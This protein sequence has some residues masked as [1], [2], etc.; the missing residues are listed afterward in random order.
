VLSAKAD[1]LVGYTGFA[2][3]LFSGVAG[4]A[5][6]VLRRRNPDEPRPFRA[7]GYPLAPGIFV[8]V[9]ALILLNAIWRSPGPTGAGVLV[10][11]AGL[12][13]YYWLR[14]AALRATRN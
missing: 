6:F 4:A 12:P 7:W 9:S 11:L 2:V 14:S 5:L 8:V 10:I 3:V 13:L 1:A